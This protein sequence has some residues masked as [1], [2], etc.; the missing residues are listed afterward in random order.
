[1]QKLTN[2][3]HHEKKCCMSM[4]N[5]RGADHPA[6]LCSTC[7]LNIFVVCCF[8][9]IIPEPR[10]EKINVLVS[11]L[12]TAKLIWVFVFALLVFS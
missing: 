9:S 5:N 12:V 8:N 11:D 10:H 7:M 1:M 6:H 2:K 3:T 4:Q